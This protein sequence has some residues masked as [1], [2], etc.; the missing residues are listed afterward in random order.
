MGGRRGGRQGITAA[1]SRA[2][3]TPPSRSTHTCCHRYLQR[4]RRRR[5]STGR[6][7]RGSARCLC[8]R[9]CLLPVRTRRSTGSKRQRSW[10]PRLSAAGRP[11]P[12]CWSGCS[13]S[14][15]AATCR[16]SRRPCRT[17]RRLRGSRWGE[18]RRLR[19]VHLLGECMQA[20]CRAAGGPGRL[21]Q[22]SLR[23]R[24]RM[25]ARRSRTRAG[26]ARRLAQQAAA[27]R[28]QAPQRL[29]VGSHPACGLVGRGRQL[30]CRE[31]AQKP[32]RQPS[33]GA[34]AAM[35]PPPPSWTR[36]RARP[37]P[38]RV[39]AMHSHLPAVR[40]GGAEEDCGEQEGPAALHAC[41]CGTEGQSESCVELVQG[42]N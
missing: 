1:A 40:E 28:Q 25:R 22:G 20:E 38:L 17:G 6:R 3:P 8:H 15:A 4:R 39:S 42:R 12:E 30:G 31:S 33:G 13:G 36:R 18:V 5:C 32:G 23:A 16:R 7:S 19:S 14:T 27:G 21:L 35:S 10:A 34:E 9:A 26:R 41:G 37:G 11:G 24:C 29:L 2:L